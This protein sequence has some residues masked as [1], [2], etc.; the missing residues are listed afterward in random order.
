MQGIFA[1]PKDWT[2]RN[3]RRRDPA[4]PEIRAR[5]ARD[6]NEFGVKE[7]HF[8][9]PLPAIDKVLTM[10]SA[11][12]SAH[13]ITPTSGDTEVVAIEPESEGIGVYDLGDVFKNEARSLYVDGGHTGWNDRC[14]RA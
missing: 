13:S 12:R 11:R 7:A 4:R 14:K 6:G 2:T 3:T 1:G 8:L 5:D 9:Q 10:T